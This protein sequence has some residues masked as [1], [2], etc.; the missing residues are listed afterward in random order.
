MQVVPH[1]SMK[2]LATAENLDKWMTFSK[3]SPHIP[4]K[5]SAFIKAKKMILASTQAGIKTR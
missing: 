2:I 5:R 1:N 4:L 3:H